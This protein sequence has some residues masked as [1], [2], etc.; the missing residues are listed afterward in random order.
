MTMTRA[1]VRQLFGAAALFLVLQYGLVGV[2]G[3]I[4]SEPWPAVVLPGF[5]SVY[6]TTD[7]VTVEKAAIEVVFRG[8]NRT[9]V[10]TPRF[11]APMPRSHQASFLQKQCRPASLSGTRATERCRSESGRQWFLQRASHLFPNR[12]VRH[13]NVQWQRLRFDPETG[14]TTR[15]PRATIL[16]SESISGPPGPATSVSHPS[17]GP[18]LFPSAIPSL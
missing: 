4:A 10:E 16:L 18:L 11:L 14:R 9:A 7:A 1:Q 6:A 17:P 5:K 3:L 15:I 8:G 12:S 13:V 2:I